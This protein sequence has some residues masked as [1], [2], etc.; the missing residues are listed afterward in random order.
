[1][2]VHGP[3][4][5]MVQNGT[6]FKI[7]QVRPGRATRALA[8]AAAWLD[9]VSRPSAFDTTLGTLGTLGEL[10]RFHILSP[11]GKK[12]MLFVLN[13]CLLWSWSEGVDFVLDV[14]QNGLRLSLVFDVVL[15][16]NGQLKSCE[17][18]PRPF[19][20]PLESLY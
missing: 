14:R 12:T 9:P 15:H 6:S 2:D 4:W 10:C 17:Q 18:C 20:I 11:R 1:M 19:A 8:L 5:Y 16:A 7:F 13:S 3:S